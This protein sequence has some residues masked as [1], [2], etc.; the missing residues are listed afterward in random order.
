MVSAKIFQNMVSNFPQS[1]FCVVYSHI[2]EANQRQTVVMHQT[3]FEVTHISW[4]GEI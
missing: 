4:N 1:I 3:S 2:L